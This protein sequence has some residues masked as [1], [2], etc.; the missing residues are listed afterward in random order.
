MTGNVWEW[1]SDWF[2]SHAVTSENPCCAPD[3]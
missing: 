3:R 1:T 2:T